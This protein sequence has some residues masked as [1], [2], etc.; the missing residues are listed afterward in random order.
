MT[1]LAARQSLHNRIK[2]ATRDAQMAGR[3]P[4][5]A[6]VLERDGVLDTAEV[7]RESMAR[8]PAVHCA[9]LGRSEDGY[10]SA[11]LRLAAF[12]CTRSRVPA[13]PETLE[14]LD[15]VESAMRDIADSTRKITPVRT[16]CLYEPAMAAKGSVTLWAV[17]ATLPELA[18]VPDHTP[19]GGVWA[20]ADAMLGPV[21]DQVLGTA[22]P[23]ETPEQEAQRLRRRGM[24]ARHRSQLLIG[25]E[26]PFA[27][28][29]HAPGR[30]TQEGAGSGQARWTDDGGVVRQTAVRG[31]IAWRTTV[32]LWA[33][34]DAQAD[35]LAAELMRRLPSQWTHLGQSTRVR[36][37][38]VTPADYSEL[39]GAS[40]ATVE[41]RLTAVS[42]RGDS[43]RVPIIRSAA[44]TCRIKTRREE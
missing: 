21:I 15:L 14:V 1:L 8:L 18:A 19:A 6:I 26:L 25:D 39:H 37:G 29:Q 12:V 24:T 38:E 42:P 22:R 4:R 16:R 36:I 11:G 31:M 17:T 43:A 35:T 5:P 40:R 20:A 7:M 28:V 27:A 2:R 10:G 9:V 32:T 41:V 33:G 3:L 23:S 30:E 34:T 13:P 44:T